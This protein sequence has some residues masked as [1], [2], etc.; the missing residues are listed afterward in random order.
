MQ[1]EYSN[2]KDENGKKV[3]QVSTSEY[4]FMTIDDIKGNH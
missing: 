4:W 1:N 3:L 2:K